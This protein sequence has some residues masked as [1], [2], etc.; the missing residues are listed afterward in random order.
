MEKKNNRRFDWGQFFVTV[1]EQR[2]R[3]DIMPYDTLETVL[4][5]LTDSQLD[6]S[7]DTS[8][9]KIFNSDLD[10]WQNLGNMAFLDNVQSFY[11]DRQV[12]QEGVNQSTQWKSPI[13]DEEYMRLVMRTG[14]ITQE[15]FAAFLV[16]LIAATVGIFWAYHHK[17]G[18][19]GGVIIDM[20]SNEGGYM[21]DFRYTVG[22]LVPSGGYH[23]ANARFK[24]GPGRYDYSPV[25][26]QPMPSES[27]FPRIH[28]SG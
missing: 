24:R 14:W 10:T 17:A 20:R 6:F 11:H 28:T 2:D 13:P 12:F 4:G 5:L 27:A 16:F 3:L 19:L 26:P 15:E 8:K 18:D 23:Y 1:L 7:F 9:E 25:M 21:S 22:A